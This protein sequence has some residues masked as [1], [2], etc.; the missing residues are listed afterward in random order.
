MNKQDETNQLEA[1]DQDQDARDWSASSEEEI[2]FD[3]GNDQTPERAH[4]V[5]EVERNSIATP[6][7]E[8]TMR[9]LQQEGDGRST[10]VPVGAARSMSSIHSGASNNDAEERVTGTPRP[11]VFNELEDTPSPDV[12]QFDDST[13]R[14]PSDRRSSIDPM[15]DLTNAARRVSNAAF[16]SPLPMGMDTRRPTPPDERRFTLPNP[17]DELDDQYDAPPIPPPAG[18]G[19]IPPT[20]GAGAGG[21]P[22]PPSSSSS[23]T[24]HHHTPAPSPIP[25]PRVKRPTNQPAAPGGD[26]LHVQGRVLRIRTIPRAFNDAGVNRI[27]D[28][29]H[30]H[31]LPVEDRLAFDGKAGGYC[32]GKH[33]KLRLLSNKI[34]DDEALMKNCNL[35]QQ[36]RAIRKHCDEYDI[37]DVFT[38]LVPVDMRRSAALLPQRFNFFDEYMHLDADLVAQSNAYYNRFCDDQFIIDNLTLTYNMLRCNTD[39]KLFL[40]CLEEYDRYQPCQQGGPLM[41][42]LLLKKINSGTEQQLDYLKAKA[43]VLRISSLEGESVDQAISL[44]DA[45]LHTFTSASS[46]TLQRKPIEWEKDLIS[47]FQTSSVSS[48]NQMFYKIQN[49]VRQAADMSGGLPQ[50]PSHEKVIRLASATYNRLKLSG[51]WDVPALAQKKALV[52]QP[53]PQPRRPFNPMNTGD[54]PPPT[55]WNCKLQGHTVNNC[56]KEKDQAAIDKAREDFMAKKRERFNSTRNQQPQQGARRANVAQ[57]QNETAPSLETQEL[58]ANLAGVAERNQHGY[59]NR[60]LEATLSNL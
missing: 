25:P 7:V 24:S 12:F 2:R 18:V 33:N 31:L 35:Q 50:W 52:S 41:L 30:R 9:N 26:P 39:D 49:E 1:Q 32:L 11:G 45:A 53:Q 21:D 28:K 48:F 58:R 37:S 56:P 55:C 38:V 40:K 34:D 10:T 16:N 6:S 22:G 14:A 27:W 36:L 59:T 5:E 47:I 20:V 15:L 8:T 29:Y 44:L 51:D 46:A 23:D 43:K 60:N 3:Q 4:V 19:T 54:R 13:P 57:L 17:T 42:S